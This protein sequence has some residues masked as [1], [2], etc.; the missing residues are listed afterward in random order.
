MIATFPPETE[1][2]AACQCKRMLAL[3]SVHVKSQ[4]H[5]KEYEGIPCALSY[6]STL[7]VD[8]HYVHLH[9]NHYRTA[10]AA[11]DYYLR[12]PLDGRP[13]VCDAILA[14]LYL[15]TDLNPAPADLPR[16]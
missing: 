11:P 1:R 13:A 3:T 9:P 5:E 7:H 14:D 2:A 6:D 16:R 12:I 10:L 8:A 15:V 4:V